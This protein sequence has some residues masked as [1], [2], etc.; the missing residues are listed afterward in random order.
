MKNSQELQGISAAEAAQILGVHELSV[1]LLV[2]QC[3]LHKPA[4]RQQFALD[5][6]EVERLALERFKPGAP[7][8]LTSV[9]AG[10]VLELQRSPPLDGDDAG[11]TVG[12]WSR[13]SPM[14]ARRGCC[15]R[16]NSSRALGARG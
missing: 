4:R 6:D 16:R 11:D 5:R 1:A 13:S 15:A 2:R 3:V 9:E 12:T 7:Y 10:Q 14:L 8:R